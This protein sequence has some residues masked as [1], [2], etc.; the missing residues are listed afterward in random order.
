MMKRI[1]LSGVLALGVALPQVLAQP[2]PKS[3]AEADALKTMFSA[4]T[5]D[6]RIA[7]CENVLTKFA[8]SDFKATV[9]YFEAISYQQKGNYEQSV[10]LGER[11][12]EADP[13]HYQVM[14]MLASSIAQHTKEFDLDREEKLA[15]VEKYAHKALELLKDAPKPNSN[16]T[17]DQWAAAKKDF[18]SQGHSALGMGAMAAKKYDAAEK[19]F[20]AAIEMAAQPDPATMVRLGKVYSDDGKYDDA[21]AQF[22]KVMAMPDINVTVKQVAQAERVRTIQKKGGANPATPPKPEAPKPEAPKP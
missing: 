4:Q 18:A 14:L 8:D 2:K 13:K 11:A 3:Q 17:D 6:Q 9:L 7:A 21:I 5:A 1:I 20:N 19:E 16:L 15:Q 22:D 12:L 10:V